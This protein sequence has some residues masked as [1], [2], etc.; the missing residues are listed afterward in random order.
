MKKSLLTHGLVLLIGLGVGYVAS[1]DRHGKSDTKDNAAAVSEPSPKVRERDATTSA[2]VLTDEDLKK[3]IT[4]I[5]GSASPVRN[6]AELTI[7]GMEAAAADLELATRTLESIDR[8]EKVA[9]MRG[10]ASHIA[11]SLRAEEAIEWVRGI[12][13]RL[14]SEGLLALVSSWTGAHLLPSLGIENMAS[15]LMR[16]E[17]V[18]D[19]IKDGWIAAFSDHPM[20]NS[21]LAERAVNLVQTDIDG[22]LALGDGLT[23]WERDQ[24]VKRMTTL[25]AAYDA[26]AAWE[27]VGANRDNVSAKSV[28]GVLSMMVQKDSDAALAAFDTL[29]D[30]EARIAAAAGLAAMQTLDHGTQAAVEWADSLPEAAEQ[31]AAHEQIYRE[32]PRGIGAML[33]EDGGAVRIQGIVPGT[34]AAIAGLQKGDRIVEIDSD[35]RGSF[36]DVSGRGLLDAI[37][38]IRGDAGSPLQLRILRDDGHGGVSEQVLSLNRPQLVLPGSS[39]DEHAP[40]IESAE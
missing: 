20:R 34:P 23:G 26:D 21:M 2:S 30:G 36:Q 9:F 13:P 35:G 14:E 17:S 24:F 19:E 7:L 6:V 18:S 25:W 39:A 12:D 22:A 1:V 29:T 3:S 31:E 8:H 33:S 5:A 28:A 37:S 40:L 27:W 15:A 32:T 16:T 11:Q 10:I 38:L 4:R